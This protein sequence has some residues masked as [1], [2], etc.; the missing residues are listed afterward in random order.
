M[1]DEDVDME[2]VSGPNASESKNKQKQQEL[3]LGKRIQ[4]MPTL[5]TPPVF[6]GSASQEKLSFM[7]A[8][9]AYCRQLAALEIAFFFHSACR[10]RSVLRMSGA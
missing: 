6:Q 1:P 10:W 2:D 5:H 4:T 8:Y 3:A 7:K 9:E